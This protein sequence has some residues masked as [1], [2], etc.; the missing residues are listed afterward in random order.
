MHAMSTKHAMGLVI[1]AKGDA[2]FSISN[3]FKEILREQKLTT[4]TYQTAFGEIT[5]Q[6]SILFNIVYIILRKK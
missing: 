6:L 4:S 5:N 3:I 1:D 2:E